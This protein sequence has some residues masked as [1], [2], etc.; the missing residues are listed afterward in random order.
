MKPGTTLL[1]F[2]WFSEN[3]ATEFLPLYLTNLRHRN[4][5]SPSRSDEG[6]VA[7]V[8]ETRSGMRWPQRCRTLRPSKDRKI[9]G[10]LQRQTTA[11]RADGPSACPGDSSHERE[12]DGKTAPP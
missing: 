12:R 2:F 5:Y 7:R 1:P 9:F 3:K 11:Q 4:I 6:R 8:F 10:R